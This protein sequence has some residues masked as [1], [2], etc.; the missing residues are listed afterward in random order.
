MSRGSLEMKICKSTRYQKSV[1]VRYQLYTIISLPS[2][3]SL[4]V[5]Q[6]PSHLSLSLPKKTAHCNLSASWVPTNFPLVVWLTHAQ[7]TSSGQVL[8]SCFSVFRNSKG[9]TGPQALPTMPVSLTK[10][11]PLCPLSIYSVNCR[12]HAFSAFFILCVQHLGQKSKFLL[13]VR[14]F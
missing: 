10:K 1:S 4:Q 6:A 9:P 3:K 8:S 7:P 2:N 11:M 12:L 5:A 13:I 14:L